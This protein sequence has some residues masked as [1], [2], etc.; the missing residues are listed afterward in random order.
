MKLIS[1]AVVWL[2]ISVATLFAHDY[3]LEADKPHPLLQ[4]KITLRL[5]FGENF[6]CGLEKPLQ[7]DRIA[8]FRLYGQTR[9][10]SDLPI[11]PQTTLE[12]TKD[13][14]LLVAM[15]RSP[16]EISFGRA[17]FLE[18]TAQE[19]NVITETDLPP[20]QKRVNETYARYL[21]TLVQVGSEPT[22]TATKTIGQ[23]YEIIPLTNPFQ[24]GLAELKVKV[25]FQGKPA[26]EVKVAAIQRLGGKLATISAITDQK[27]KCVLPITQT[28]R[29][30]IRSVK[31]VPDAHAEGEPASY[32]S[33]WSVLT[34]GYE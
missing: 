19:G 30:L 21:K 14:T 29:W 23:T 28:G 11:Q 32:H 22:K 3:W 15:E 1:S 12:A 25:L 5:M 26:V 20:T 17:K 34:F 8:T 31:I 27:G 7:P 18:Y 9:K 16:G 24:N 4:E 10:F 33:Y 6:A 2:M 13:G